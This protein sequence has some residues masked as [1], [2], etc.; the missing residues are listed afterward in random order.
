MTTE[1][2]TNLIAGKTPTEVSAIARLATDPILQVRDGLD[3]TN[4]QVVSI[5]GAIKFCIF[6]SYEDSISPDKYAV[7]YVVYVNGP[8]SPMYQIT[9]ADIE[10][11][12]FPQEA[13]EGLRNTNLICAR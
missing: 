1:Q 10:V 2:L 6:G 11:L 5:P 8:M 7:G 12:K 4:V 13:L 9:E 3:F